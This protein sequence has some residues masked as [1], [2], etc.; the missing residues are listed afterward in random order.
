[1]PEVAVYTF[2]SRSVQE[3]LKELMVKLYD[4]FPAR[5]AHPCSCQVRRGSWKT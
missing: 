5:T 4:A 1:M 3:M 2:R